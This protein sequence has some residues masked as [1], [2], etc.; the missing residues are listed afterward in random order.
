MFGEVNKRLNQLL[1]K[2]LN[3]NNL[4]L[5]FTGS[6]YNSNLLDPSNKGL[7]MVNQANANVSV[8]MPLFNGRAAFTIG[9]TVDVPLQADIQQKLKLF[10][11]V[12]LELLINKSGSVRASFFYKQNID[13]LTEGSQASTRYGA[14]LSYNK[15]F[16]TPGEVFQGKKQGKKKNKNDTS[17]KMQ[18]DTTS[19]Q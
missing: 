9:G 3:N 6:L 13:Y 18:S 2:I 16:D 17:A 5:N 4:T 1:S 12:T 8:G 10:P 15:D 7:R 11:D 14:S 19:T